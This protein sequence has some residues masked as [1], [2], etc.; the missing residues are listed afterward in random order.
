M[1]MRGQEDTYGMGAGASVRKGNVKKQ[2]SK[3]RKNIN[4]AKKKSSMVN[5]L[6]TSGN[7]ERIAKSTKTVERATADKIGKKTVMKKKSLY[8]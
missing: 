5:A 8:K 4:A 1:A 7:A 2:V 6:T 3:A